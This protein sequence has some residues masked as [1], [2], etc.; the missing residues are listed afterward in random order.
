MNWLSNFLKSKGLNFPV[1]GILEFPYGKVDIDSIHGKIDNVWVGG[2]RFHE[3]V[4]NKSQ[5]NLL[6]EQINLI[7]DTLKI[8]N[9]V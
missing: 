9:T 7:V 4:I 3:Y 6:P 1:T 5:Q 8:F 2:S